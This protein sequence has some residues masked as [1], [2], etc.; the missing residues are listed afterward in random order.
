MYTVK[1]L[2]DLNEATKPQGAVGITTTGR[3]DGPTVGLNSTYFATGTAMPSSLSGLE[4]M[5]VDEYDKNY[6]INL[7]N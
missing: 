5:V 1:D 4:V 7:G 2:L 3:V 6:Y